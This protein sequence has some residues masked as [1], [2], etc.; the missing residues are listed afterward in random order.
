[1][2]FITSD[3]AERYCSEKLKQDVSEE[4]LK[5]II[6]FT[7]LFNIKSLE[8]EANR[9]LGDEY[10]YK[11]KYIQAIEHYTKVLDFYN[12]NN[13]YEKIPFLYNRIGACKYAEMKYHEALELFDKANISAVVYNDKTAE[14][15]SILNS[16]MCYRR[17]SWLDKAIEYADVCISQTGVQTNSNEHVMA[18]MIKINCYHDKKDFQKAFELSYKL[19]NIVKDGSKFNIGFLYNNMGNLCIELGKFNDA[20]EFF[21]KSLEYR[22]KVLWIF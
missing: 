15:H 12:K 14:I 22:R 13:I 18:H 4:D 11:Y 2:Q 6:K 21:D 10:F 7:E 5:E 16:A 20:I 17:L 1:M 19:A 8:A 3:E 9:I